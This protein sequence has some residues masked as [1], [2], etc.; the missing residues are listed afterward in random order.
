MILA[1]LGCGG[2]RPAAP[3]VNVDMLREQLKIGTPERINLDAEPNYVEHDLLIPLPWPDNSIGGILLQHVIEHFNCHDSVKILAE[4]RRVLAVGATVVVSVP[5]AEYFLSV[6]SQDTRENA[7][8]LFG[9]PISEPQYER[10]FDYAL[11]HRCHIQILTY[12][13]LRCIMVKAGFGE[14]AIGR[15][16]A[17]DSPI[18]DQLNRKMFS[19]VLLARKVL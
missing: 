13:S 15:L 3:W 2:N 4:C 10:F 16:G 9:E 8:H 17:W 6:L 1:N 12:T 7:I 19:A 5:D 14:S 18:T 11:L